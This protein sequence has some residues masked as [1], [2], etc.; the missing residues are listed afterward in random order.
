MSLAEEKVDEA[1]TEANGRVAA[2]KRTAAAGRSTS[3]DGVFAEDENGVSF[4]ES[5][6]RKVY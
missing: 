6:F 2:A 3:A 1:I 4:E 5:L